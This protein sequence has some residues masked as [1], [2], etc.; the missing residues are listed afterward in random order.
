MSNP[1]LEVQALQKSFG[2]LQVLRGIDLSVEAGERIA[3][4]GGSGSGKS[5]LL[6]CLNFMEMPTSGSIVLDGKRLGR[7]RKDRNGGER[8]TYPES[9]LCSVRERIGMVFQQFNLFPH[10]TVIENTMEALRTVKRA[11][12]DVAR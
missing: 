1:I 8:V 12:R 11:S 4:I 2:T 3:I 9:E 7:V 5:T 10:M 6:R